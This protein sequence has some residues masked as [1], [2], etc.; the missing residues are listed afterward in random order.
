MFL[1]NSDN[2]FLTG[3][4]GRIGKLMPW[5]A[6][7]RVPVIARGPGIPAGKRV[8]TPMTSPDLAVS[9]AAAAGARTGRRV[10]GIDIL[11]LIRRHPHASRVIPIEAYPVNSGHRLLYTGIRYDSWTYVRG[12]GGREELYNRRTDRGELNN[13]AGQEA[14]PPHA[15]EAPLPE[16][17]VPRLRR[18]QL[19]E[20]AGPSHLGV[21][22]SVS[23]VQGRFSGPDALSGRVTRTSGLTWAYSRM[24]LESGRV[25]SVT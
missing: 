19:S 6:S 8:S 5:D 13:L 10:D 12:R 23:T 9:I 17:A 2:G 1:F 25:R 18:R 4:H 21:A 7:L 15:R 11:G 14:L 22:R 20:G 16:P 24:V 3:H